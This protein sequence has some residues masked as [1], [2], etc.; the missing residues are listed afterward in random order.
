MKKYGIIGT[1]AVG[2]YF[3]IKLKQAKIDVHCLLRSDYDHV[4]QHGLTLIS[5]NLKSNVHVN[6]YNNANDMPVCDVILITL[7]TFDNN[8]LKDILPKLTNKNTVVIVLQ[9]G[10]EIEEEIRNI[11]DEKNI[12]GASTG[13]LVSRVSSGIIKH[14]GFYSLDLANFTNKK[15]NVTEEIISTFEAAN[16]KCVKYNDLQSLR[17]KK[18]VINIP[19]SGLQVVLNSNMQSLIENEYS[20]KL[21]CE[22]TK[23]VI[24]TGE[25]CGAK[26]PENFYEIRLKTFQDILN[27]P[28]YYNSMKEDFDADRKIELDSI[29]KNALKNANSYDC[30]M[31]L[32]KMLYNQI[33]YLVSEKIRNQR[34]NIL[35]NQKL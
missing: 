31:P 26:L 3:A 29:Y 7:K 19:T 15:N 30:N 9:N 35:C 13:I 24:T 17:W 23:E 21:L 5:N 8:I 16:F 25:K 11:I 33:S 14:T 34:K 32:T 22:I 12:I 27:I 20:Y 28:P 10:I 18:L 4:K 1:G 6:A 2:G